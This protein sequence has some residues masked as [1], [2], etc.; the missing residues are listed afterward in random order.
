MDDYR[1][2][3]RVHKKVEASLTDFVIGSD[4]AIGPDSDNG[5]GDFATDS[6]GNIIET[7][8]PG[9][10][11]YLKGDKRIEINKPQGVGGYGE[12][13]VTELHSIPDHSDDI[14]S[15]TILQSG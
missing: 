4:D 10:I 7:F 6:D 5:I 12:Y 13:I 2:A 8:E 1:D 11:A 15:G 3:E 14:K 9:L